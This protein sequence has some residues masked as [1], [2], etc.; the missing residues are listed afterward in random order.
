MARY[1]AFLSYSSRD[2]AHAE[3]LH[4]R[5]EGYRVPRRLVGQE[6]G[7]GPVP[8][9]LYPI[10][11][12]RDE[13]A[14]SGDLGRDLQEAL[15]ESRFLIVLA[16]PAAAASQWVNE[17]IRTFKSLHGENR[18]LV[19]VLAGEPGASAVSEHA[20][21]EAFP[22]ALRHRV[23]PDGAILDIPAEPIAADA[24]PDG[25]GPRLALLK[26]VAGLTG[27]RLDDLVQREAQRR[28]RRLTVVATASIVGMF[29]ATALALYANIQRIEAV[30]QREIAERE[31][32][33]ARAAT[34]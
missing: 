11:R 5:L 33:A 18:V 12:D 25:D 16:S 19:L 8:A 6:T 7:L 31:T 20:S 24:R 26:L 23:G 32:A 28:A 34:D 9:R 2:R 13:L 14:A 22:E 10:F 1:L 15:A 3:S 29:L 21:E 17:E 30:E 4:R 27:V